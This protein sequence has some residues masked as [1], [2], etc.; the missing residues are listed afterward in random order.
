[1]IL[2][3]TQTVN[4]ALNLLTQTEFVEKGK[5]IGWN[6]LIFSKLNIRPKHNWHSSVV[7]QISSSINISL[8]RHI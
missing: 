2:L 6:I 8:E 5:L 1:M 7:Y 3:Q 4:K